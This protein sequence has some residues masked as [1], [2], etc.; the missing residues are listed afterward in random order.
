[1]PE[2]TRLEGKDCL[3]WR[4]P[5][6]WCRMKWKCSNLP[7]VIL[8]DWV[9]SASHFYPG[10]EPSTSTWSPRIAHAHNFLSYHRPKSWTLIGCLTIRIA[11]FHSNK[12]RR[13]HTVAHYGQHGF[14]EDKWSSPGDTG[15]AIS[16]QSKAIRLGTLVYTLHRW[17]H[18]SENYSSACWHW[19]G[20]LIYTSGSWHFVQTTLRIFKK[21]I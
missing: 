19:K 16:R 15:T 5:S 21:F 3:D 12:W 4:K 2:S 13:P 6:K 10:T 11:N 7:G 18:E 14:F 8:L 17:C 20:N 9:L 1:M